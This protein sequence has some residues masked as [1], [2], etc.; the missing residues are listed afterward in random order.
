MIVRS[1]SKAL[2]ALLVL[3]SAGCADDGA[4]ALVVV[5]LTT[6]MAVGFD[7]DEIEI[8]TEVAGVVTRRE[9]LS[10]GGG[11]L[12][13]P[14]E[15]VVGPAHDGA[16]VEL[17]VAAF[18]DGEALPIV[19]RAAATRAVSGRR[20]LLPVPLDEACVAVPCAGGATC[21][22][23]A[24]VDPFIAPS[25]L[26]G[27]DP[28]WIVSARDACKTPDSGAPAVMIGQGESGFAPLE[29]GEVVSIEA[30]P[31]GG[32]HVWLALRVT[33]LRQMGSRLR[34]GGHYP[35]LGVEL[36]PFS[37]H[38]TLHRAGQ[39]LCGIHG[40]RF[41][42]DRGLLVESVRGRALDIDIAVE[43]PN[44]DVATAARRVVISP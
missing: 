21:A 40:V 25:A 31:Q 18:R 13:L 2:L 26:A 7:I 16:A 8:T 1:T 11:G 29:E 38:I 19:T 43:D 32:H 23:G 34:V 24:C 30:G 17:S 6:D 15:L 9:R 39:G 22:E 5:G 27:H 33:G 35:E 44:G 14:A 20:L 42:V 10:Y 41:Q 4:D 3:G 36:L 37:A 28:M 12:A